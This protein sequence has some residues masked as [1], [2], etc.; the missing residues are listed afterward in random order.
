[1]KTTYILGFPLMALALV[2]C[3]SQTEQNAARENT[4]DVEVTS[5]AAGRISFATGEVAQ[6]SDGSMT[7]AHGPVEDIGWPAMTMAF[8][9]QSPD[10]MQDIAVGDQVRFGFRESETG[11]ALTSVEKVE[12]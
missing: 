6:I 2:S 4:K 11:Y 3:G 7:I 9:A 5:D 8:E 12:P 10:M 1:M